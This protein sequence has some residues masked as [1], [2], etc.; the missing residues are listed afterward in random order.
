[1]VLL[2]WSQTGG[3]RRH[4]SLQW[5]VWRLWRAVPLVWLLQRAFVPSLYVQCVVCA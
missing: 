2:V 4:P 5:Q 3:L 1:M